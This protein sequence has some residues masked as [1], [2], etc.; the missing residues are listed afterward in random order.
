MIMAWE[1][2]GKKISLGEDHR[3]EKNIHF[4]RRSDRRKVFQRIIVAILREKGN[5]P[6][7]HYFHYQGCK[8][9]EKFQRWT[10]TLS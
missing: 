1:T 7:T 2:S 5:I 6:P 8:R 4:R 9:R 10:G 3:G